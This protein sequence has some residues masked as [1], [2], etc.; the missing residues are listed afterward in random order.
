MYNMQRKQVRYIGLLLLGGWLFSSCA[1]EE[2]PQESFPGFAVPSHFPAP[3][4]QF[5]QNPL[6]ADGFF[7]GRKLFYEPLLSLDG[8]VSCGNCHAQVHAFADHNV[9]FSKGIYGR[10]GLRNAPQLSN[11]AWYPAFMWDGGINHIEVMPVAPLT[12]TLEMG[13]SWQQIIQKLQNHP[14]YP[15]L[16]A[17]AFGT[18]EINDQRI[19]FAFAQFM[20]MMISSDSKYDRYINGKTSFTEMEEAGLEVFR[21]HCESCHAEPL[22]T[23]FSYRNN[24]LDVVSADPGRERITN[25]PSDKGKFKVPGL[26]NITLTYPYMHDGRFFTLQQVL[27]HYRVGI[28]PAPNLD[29]S[30]SQG[31]PLTDMEKQQL[32]AFLKTLRDDTYLTNSW[33]AEPGL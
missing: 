24:G 30:L 31:I 29:P 14:E 10:T 17:K 15:S 22:F 18:P 11:L 23:D 25:N 9:N 32:L 20:G 33:F 3:H 2:E 26:R 28:Q 12:D 16:F 19:L 4:Y 6:T 21:T 7:L 27:D 13:E 1:K 5:G 8:T